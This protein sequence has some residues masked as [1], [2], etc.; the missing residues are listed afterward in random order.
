M[1]SGKGATGIRSDCG[2]MAEMVYDLTSYRTPDEIPKEAGDI[3]RVVAGRAARRT[4]V[5]RPAKRARM[6]KTET[7]TIDDG[8]AAAAAEAGPA[9]S[10]MEVD[11]PILIDIKVRFA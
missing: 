8:A 5:S 7:V 3:P 4:P 11:E 9:A 1:K 6:A 10:S 2:A